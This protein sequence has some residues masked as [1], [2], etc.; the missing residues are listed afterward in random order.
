MVDISIVIP[1][2]NASHCIEATCR[3]VETYLSRMSDQYEIIVVD[4]GS[5]DATRKIAEALTSSVKNLRVISH[6][7]NFGKGRAVKSGILAASGSL[8]L[9]MD[10][11]SSTDILYLSDAM[12]LQERGFDVVIA[13]RS[14]KDAPGAR[15][16]IPQNF[17]RRTSGRLGNFIIRA[18]GLHGIRDTQCGFKLFT[19]DAAEKLFR[20]SRIDGFGFDVE[21]LTLARKFGFK[22]GIIPVKWHHDSRS[23]VTLLSYL[24][25][26]KDILVIRFNMMR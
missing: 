20:M 21:I 10:A 13:S 15:Q 18:F 5:K 14:E 22:I 1:A 17:L 19:R 26:L 3:N 7:R 23:S 8:R 4:D 9:F 16:V 11:D 24:Q 12:K 25:M 6:G 2:Y